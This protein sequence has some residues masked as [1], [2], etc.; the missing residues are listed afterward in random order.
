[1]LLSYFLPLFVWIWMMGFVTYVQHTHPKIIWL[2]EGERKSFQESVL[3]TSNRV[4][5]NQ[6]MEIAFLNI[7]EHTAHHMLPN[8]PLYNLKKAQRALEAEYPSTIVIIQNLVREYF[9]TAFV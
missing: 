1:M 5:F 6:F 2:T 3:I 7:M 8:I 9:D 4:S